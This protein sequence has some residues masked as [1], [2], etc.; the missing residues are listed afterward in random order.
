MGRFCNPSSVGKISPAFESHRK[1]RDMSGRATVRVIS[2]GTSLVRLPSKTL[3]ECGHPRSAVQCP[4]AVVSNCNK[5]RRAGKVTRPWFV[6]KSTS[7]GSLYHTSALA[8]HS[9][10]NSVVVAIADGTAARSHLA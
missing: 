1:V 5:F 9:V 4:Q 7:R 3:R 8:G 6:L 2:P 10:E